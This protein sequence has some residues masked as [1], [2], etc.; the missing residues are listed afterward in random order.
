MPIIY[1]SRAGTDSFESL[2]AAAFDMSGSNAFARAA[3]TGVGAGRRGCESS[4]SVD[5]CFGIR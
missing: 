4:R 2:G 1:L 5:S 3:A